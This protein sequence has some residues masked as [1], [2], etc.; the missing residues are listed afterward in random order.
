MMPVQTLLGFFAATL[1][2]FGAITLLSGT[3]GQR[4]MR[5]AKTERLMN[6]IAGTMFGLLALKRVTARRL[7]GMC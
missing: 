2:V 5:S 3:I 7:P 1:L 4:R 6:R